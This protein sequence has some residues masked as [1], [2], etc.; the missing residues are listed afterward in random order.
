MNH[1]HQLTILIIG[2]LMLCV[3]TFGVIIASALASA[4][5]FLNELDELDEIN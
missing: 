4:K 5:K 2:I 1:W 3:I